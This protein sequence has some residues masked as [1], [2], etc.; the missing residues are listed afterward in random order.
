IVN[1]PEELG[2]RCVFQYGPNSFRLFNLPIVRRG[3]VVGLLG[4]NGVGKTT[5]V[6]ILVGQLKPNL[7]EYENPPSW[8]EITRFFRG[9]ELQNYFE[10]LHRGRIRVVYKPQRIS[11]LPTSVRGK[12][13][14]LLEKV[15][16]RGVMDYVVEMLSLKPILDREIEKLSGG[17]LQQVSIAASVCK[18]AD[19]YIFDEP[20][21]YVD[22][23]QRMKIARLIR[24]LTNEDRAVMVVE[25]DLA[26][27]DFLSDFVHVL[28]G[29]PGVYGIVSG[30]YGVREGIN[31][32][33]DGYLRGEN[34]RF[35]KTPITFETRK[36][37]GDMVEH[38]VLCDF[39]GITKS[40]DGFELVVEG[41]TL[42]RSEVVGIMGP[43]GIGKTTFA[44]LLAGKLEPTT[45]TIPNT[46]RV[47]LKPQYLEPREGKQVCSILADAAPKE[48]G[49]PSYQNTFID[50]L[51]LEH[52]LERDVAELS[53][54]ELQ[55]VAIAETLSREADIYLLDEPTA[56]L[57]VDERITI[58]KVIRTVVE[59]REAVGLVVDHDVQVIDLVSDRLMIF[60]GEPGVK[61]FGR[62]PID[63]FEGMNSFL[64]KMGITYRRDPQTGR[65]RVN[66]PGS[67]LDREQKENKQY[68]YTD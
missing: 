60:E 52:L 11:P 2:D 47:A 67:R 37:S 64:E 51:G 49:T 34:I 1:L 38:S 28:F 25:H 42:R 10:D 12:V 22:I 3:V 20:S 23:F 39:R 66:K 58:S 44:M 55:R 4:P 32:F 7:G 27:L 21:S 43:N 48:Y 56:F 13:E 36:P 57:D 30:I 62:G 61:G 8:V 35:R 24:T 50:P 59:R 26:I 31:N 6:R 45:G 40:Y 17:E 5:A 46:F 65:P 53:G 18:D 15:D 29:K 16:E 33:L 19:L 9:S 14:S 63:K 68:Y 54:G 41:G